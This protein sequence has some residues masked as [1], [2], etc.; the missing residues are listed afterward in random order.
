MAAGTG[1]Y[2]KERSF[3]TA[4][5][6]TR[7]HFHTACRMLSTT[8][9]APDPAPVPAFFVATQDG[10]G[11]G[12]PDVITINVSGMPAAGIAQC[13]AWAGDASHRIPMMERANE[14]PAFDAVRIIV[15]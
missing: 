9:G 3:L 13:A 10:G 15:G 11:G 2:Y 7:G 8:R 4:E 6:L 5:G 12:N 1:G 14:V